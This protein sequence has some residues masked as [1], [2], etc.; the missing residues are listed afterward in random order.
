MAYT[1]EET[2]NIEVDY[3]IK[4]LWEG[5]PKAIEK[6]EWTV[7]DADKKTYHIA[8]KTR[9]AFLSYP[10]NM[11]IDLQPVNDNTTRML[12]SGETPVTTITSVLDFGRTSERIERFVVALAQI[13]E[14]KK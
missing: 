5:I 10:S 2:E 12:I 13:M 1:R 8:I 9:G 6:L 4:Q 3:P 7:L 14:K 11:K